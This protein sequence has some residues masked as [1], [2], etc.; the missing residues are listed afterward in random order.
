MRR[1]HIQRRK[2]E[3]EGKICNLLA[4]RSI[5]E[6][7]FGSKNV[8]KILKTEKEAFPSFLALKLFGC[9]KPKSHNLTPELNFFTTLRTLSFCWLS[10]ENGN[11][12]SLRNMP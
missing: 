10:P 12:I 9:W 3:V 7:C 5:K 4:F 2:E 8:L 6:R 11:R 1:V